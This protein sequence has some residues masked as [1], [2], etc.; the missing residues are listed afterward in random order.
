MFPPLEP[1]VLDVAITSHS[2]RSTISHLVP[3][4][5][6]FFIELSFL[7]INLKIE[8]DNF[9]CKTIISHQAEKVFVFLL[10]FSIKK[11]ND[12]KKLLTNKAKC[13]LILL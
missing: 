1:G 11:L 5:S 6:I 13:G 8:S 4:Y 3:E 7:I 10:G 12:T 2:S 9:T